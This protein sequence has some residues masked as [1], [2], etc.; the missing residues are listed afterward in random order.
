MPRSKSFLLPVAV[1]FSCLVM[2]AAASAERTL[3]LGIGGVDYRVELALTPE[4]R[5][6]GLMHRQ[7][8]DPRGGMLLVYKDEGNHRIWMKNVPIALRVFWIDRDF[9]VV[10]A[11]RLPPCE[12]DP[13]PVY[14]A[15]KP[16]LYVL[17]LAD[18]DH[19]LLPGDR[20]IGLDSLPR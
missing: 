11:R 20:I 7:Q 14:A 1:V 5:S 18:R 9:R 15:K 2:P 3:T 10:H 19:G 4:E 12:A 13:C 17:E 6:R 8:L 16:S